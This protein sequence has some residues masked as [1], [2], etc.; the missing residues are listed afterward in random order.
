MIQK[1][2]KVVTT[3]DDW[4]IHAGP[5]LDVQWQDDRSAKESARAWLSSAPEIPVELREV[6]LSHSDI[7]PLQEWSAEPEAQAPFDSFRGE[8]ANLDVLLLGR[9]SEG[10]LVVAVEAK[11]D[12]TFG[13]TISDTL[14]AARERLAANLR[15]KGVARVQ[16]LTS[17]ILGVG[18]DE[19]D[20]HGHMRY[21]LLTATAAALCV[22]ERRT[23]ER[24]VVMIHE[25]VTNRTSDEC[26]ATNA[27]DLDGFVQL[28]SEGSVAAVTP[29]ALHGP[30]TVPGSPLVQTEIRLYVGKAVRD[31]RGRGT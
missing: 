19:I 30:F 27:S 5:K 22:A 31:L 18:P 7:G 21:Q 1:S 11:A 8:P 13:A 3:L 26:H 25:F 4:H 28:I 2:G 24:A 20:T 16:Q 12:E 14:D 9:D 10:P 6:L 15:S 23:S 29:G 17:A